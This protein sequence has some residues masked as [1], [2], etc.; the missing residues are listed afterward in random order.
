M[1][2]TRVQFMRVP[3]YKRMLDNNLP[4]GQKLNSNHSS[5]AM[6]HGESDEYLSV[7]FWNLIQLEPK[8]LKTLR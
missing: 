1:S 6:P 2:I 7:S 8:L 5:G 3:N 4:T